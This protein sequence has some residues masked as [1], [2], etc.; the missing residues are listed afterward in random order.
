MFLK[1]HKRPEY[2]LYWWKWSSSGLRPRGKF[3]FS[4]IGYVL[5]FLSTSCQQLGAGL[6]LTVACSGTWGYFIKFL[7]L[8]CVVV[9]SKL[10]NFCSFIFLHVLIPAFEIWTSFR[11]ILKQDV[12]TT[13]EAES[14][15]IWRL[16]LV[17]KSFHQF[18]VSGPTACKQQICP[19]SYGP[20]GGTTTSEQKNR[21]ETS[22][23]RRSRGLF[24]ITLQIYT[25]KA[26]KRRAKWKE[27]MMSRLSLHH[28]KKVY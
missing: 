18:F 8:I 9:H 25:R 13:N 1:E 11:A 23:R 4:A 26:S 22:R 15:W 17:N 10:W 24:S 12:H 3:S 2:S 5:S 16:S 28:V 20:N 27:I 14:T 6:V 19:N 7:R 21:M